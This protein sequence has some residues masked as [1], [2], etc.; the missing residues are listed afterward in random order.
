MLIRIIR[1]ITLYSQCDLMNKNKHKKKVTMKGTKKQIFG[2]LGLILVAVVTV[3]AALL[4]DAGSSAMGR[5]APN[6]SSDPSAVH[7]Q[8]K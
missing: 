7:L 1:N 2:I 4:P 8:K 3:F 6:M 5:V